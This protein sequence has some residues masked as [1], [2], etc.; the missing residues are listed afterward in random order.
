[1]AEKRMVL[2]DDDL[3][4]KIDVN[5][6]EMSRTA[7]LS[8]LINNQLQEEGSPHTSNQY[9]SREEYMEFTQG[10]KDLLR[11]F[12]D[13]FISYNMKLGEQPKDGTLAELEQKL[14]SL[15]A[16]KGK[17]KTSI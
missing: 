16:S 14:Q 2:V 6:R 1:M 11:N 7:F 9:V 17:P 13:S 15:S 5:R 3:L 10:M 8:F 4:S 12:L